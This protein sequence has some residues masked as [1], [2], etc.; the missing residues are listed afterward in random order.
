MPKQLQQTTRPRQSSHADTAWGSSAGRGGV[1][2]R[3]RAV[4][5]V[6]IQT[7]RE[8]LRRRAGA[9]YGGVSGVSAVAAGYPSADSWDQDD[10]EGRRAVD[11]A[12]RALRRAQSVLANPDATNPD[13]T[14]PDATNPD[15]RI[16]PS[17]EARAENVRKG[18]VGYGALEIGA[19]PHVAGGADDS[20]SGT[21]PPAWSLYPR[22]EQ[23][24]DMSSLE[25]MEPH[26]ST[27]ASPRDAY[28]RQLSH[29]VRWDYRHTHTHTHTHT[30]MHLE[31]LNTSHGGTVYIHTH[32]N[33]YICT[34][35]TSHK[36][37]L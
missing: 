37:S 32:I 21:V 4:G 19:D 26:L 25:D 9:R 20:S 31:L 1:D 30:H 33:I 13:A 2:E 17:S 6:P 8:E 14:N 11:E 15:A 28:R 3:T 7:G 36:S 24:E 23:V 16:S 10:A 12:T 34:Y 5:D 22:G 27:D 18:A 29:I 35:A